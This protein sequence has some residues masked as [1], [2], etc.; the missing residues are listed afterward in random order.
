VNDVVFE[1]DS[2]ARAAKEYQEHSGAKGANTPYVGY[3]FDTTASGG[4]YTN[5]ARPTSLRYPNGRILRCEYNSGVDDAVNRVSF[6]ADG[7][8][9]ND[10][11]TRSLAYGSQSPNYRG[12]GR[13]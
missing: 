7:C 13:E 1:F 5:G 10:W 11:A 4:F 2:L 12:S 9:L 8:E 3:N 6:L